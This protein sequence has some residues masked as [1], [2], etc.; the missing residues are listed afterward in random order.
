MTDI[1]MTGRPA[2]AQ[3]PKT[4]VAT[5]TTAYALTGANSVLDDNPLNTVLLLAAGPKGSM[6]GSIKTKARASNTTTQGGLF[7][8]KTDDAP[9]I[10]RLINT[11][12]IPT[13]SVTTTAKIT[14]YSFDIATDDKPLRLEV[15]DELY[16]GVAVSQNNGINAIAQYSDF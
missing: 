13:Q 1:V 9:G 5:A 14:E 11:V 7:L 15:G 3:F 8:R 6:V 10:R 12:T 2:F 4:A 16:F